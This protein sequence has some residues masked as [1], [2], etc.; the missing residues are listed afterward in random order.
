MVVSLWI[1]YTGPYLLDA[2]DSLQPPTR[3]FAKPLLMPICDII[4][5]TAQGQV[6]ACGKLEAGAIRSGTK[7]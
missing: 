1:R 7:V 2:I 4:K 6:S 5:S 3:E